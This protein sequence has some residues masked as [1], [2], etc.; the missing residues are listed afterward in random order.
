[1]KTDI[2]L[3]ATILSGLLASGH[4]TVAPDDDDGPRLEKTDNGKDYKDTC[5]P[6]RFTTLAIEHALDICSELEEQIE[7]NE[8]LMSD[9]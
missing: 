6:C 8:K 1:M 5:V 9:E 2:N 7:I 4:Y 3:A